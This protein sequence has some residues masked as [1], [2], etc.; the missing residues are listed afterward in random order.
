MNNSRKD[1]ETAKND[2]QT[3]KEQIKH[4]QKDIKEKDLEIRKEQKEIRR[5]I[6]NYLE[7]GRIA[8]NKDKTKIRIT[9]QD[10]AAQIGLETA[11]AYNKLISG[12]TQTIDF[13]YVIILAEFF[14]IDCKLSDFFTFSC[15]ENV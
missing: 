14:G 6:G 13:S 1:F 15:Q 8:N 11:A 10:A 2:I 7:Q 9:Q 3:A 4:Y 12:E 5:K